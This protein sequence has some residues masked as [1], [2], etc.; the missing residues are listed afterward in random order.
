M[1]YVVDT[2]VALKWVLLEADS[3]KADLLRQDYS[4]G[5]HELMAPDIFPVEIAHALTR[6]ERRGIISKGQAAPLLNV[7]LAVAPTLHRYLP[8]LGR[9]VAISSDYRVGV[10]DCVY[11]AL[12][13]REKCE[14]ITSDDKLVKNLQGA[15]PFVIPLTSLP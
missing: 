1:R 3:D 9:A 2:S 13:E 10:Y 7:A 14:L 6:A 8:L 5:L 11:V 15:F 12:A 4:N